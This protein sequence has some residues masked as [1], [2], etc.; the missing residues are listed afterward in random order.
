[1][2]ETWQW[3]K[4]DMMM[5]QMWHDGGH[6]NNEDWWLMVIDGLM[7][8]HRGV[9]FFC[10]HEVDGIMEKNR[11]MEDDWWRIKN[12]FEGDQ[13]V[14][15]DEEERLVQ[16]NDKLYYKMAW[17]WGMVRVYDRDEV[18]LSLCTSSISNDFSGFLTILGRRHYY[19]RELFVF[20]L[21][22]L[23][24]ESSILSL[25]FYQL[26]F[27]ILLG[28]NNLLRNHLMEKGSRGIWIYGVNG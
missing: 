23:Y 18:A 24:T 11:W 28:A 15:I 17:F 14:M 8:F 9:G 3:W 20:I 22:R 2:T 13:K 27:Y 10:G 5:M 16:E 26:I 19:L 4:C 1:M 6:G 12:D 7:K 25:Q 21:P